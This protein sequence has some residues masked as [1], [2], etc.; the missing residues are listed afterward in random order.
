MSQDNTKSDKI[1]LLHRD[2]ATLNAQQYYTNQLLKITD[3]K[4]VSVQLVDFAGNKTNYF[5]LN[6]VSIPILIE[7]LQTMRGDL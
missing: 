5:D 3:L 7:F 6:A 2:D 1:W 4:A